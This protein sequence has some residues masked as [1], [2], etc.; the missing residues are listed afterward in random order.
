MNLCRDRLHKKGFADPEASAKLLLTQGLGLDMSLLV[1]SP[2]YPLTAQ[3]ENQFDDY[4]ERWLPDMS[5]SRLLGRAAFWSGEY[6]ID[7][8][9]LEPRADTGALITLCL[10]WALTQ[11]VPQSVVDLGTGSG[12]VGLELA[13]AWHDA[14]VVLCDCCSGALAVAQENIK[15]SALTERV[16]VHPSD[17]FSAIN[18]SFDLLVS[19]PPYVAT[20]Y[21]LEDS[22]SRYDPHLA[23][24]SGKQ[25]LDAITV[26]LRDGQQY[27]N[28]QGALILEIGFDQSKPVKQLAEHYG[29]KLWGSEND[30]SD[31]VRALAFMPKEQGA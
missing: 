9:T 1:L 15:A 22:V 16:V 4:C 20:G 2:D 5:L 30:L 23:L 31:I 24:Y 26:L 10:R 18:D 11:G 17:W 3:Q 12:I 29:W 25:G 19:N 6:L 27:L 8:Y 7:K 14:R 28:D 21:Q 13:K